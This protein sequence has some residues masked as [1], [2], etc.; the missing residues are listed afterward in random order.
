MENLRYPLS[1]INLVN[2]GVLHHV[3]VVFGVNSF[4]REWEKVDQVR[5]TDWQVTQR[6]KSQHTRLNTG[7]QTREG[8]TESNKVSF[9]RATCKVLDLGASR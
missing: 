2:V 1:L 4:I 5:Q 9:E 8:L 3:E 7:L 6:P